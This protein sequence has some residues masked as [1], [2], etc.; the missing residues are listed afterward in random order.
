MEQTVL[1]SEIFKSIQ[2]EGHYTGVP[3]TWLRFF[4]CNLECNGFGQDDPTDPSTYK[5]PYQDFDIIEVKNVEYLPVWK[6][7]CDSSYS[8]SKKFAKI[9]KNETEE[10]VALKL[11]NQMY[12]ENTHIAF[13]GGEPLMKAAQ[14]K[15]VKILEEMER[16]CREKFSKRFKYITWE[17]NGTRPLE[18]VLQNYLMQFKDQVEYFFSV[19]P[20]MF[21]TSG[22]ED[23]VCPEIVKEYYDLS[24]GVG[25]LKFVCNGSDASWNEIEESIVKFRDAGVMYPIWIMPVGAT[26]E[27]QDD[28]AKEITIQ[29][30]F[31]DTRNKSNEFYNDV[32]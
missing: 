17:T 5:L 26:E 22:E 13:T 19:S 1:Y 10:E 18:T 29:T 9:Q 6:Y 12:D 24:D 16:L 20:K 30:I 4:G 8:W 27:S 31:M 32:R 28:N 15:T 11:F 3:T 21:N 2:G 14:K 7:G 25:Q 23:A